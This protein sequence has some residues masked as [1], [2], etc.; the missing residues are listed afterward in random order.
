MSIVYYFLLIGILLLIIE[1]IAILFKITGLDL[2]KSRF[3]TISIITHTGFTTRES[4]LI[5]QHPLHRKIAGYLMII[6]YIGQAGLI[7][8]FLNILK[9]KNYIGIF[10]IVLIIA[11]FILYFSRKR[12]A[13]SKIDL[14]I[15]KTILNKMKKN[16]KYRSVDEV[17]K[18]NDEYGVSE[19]VLNENSTLCN[20]SLDKSNL[21]SRNIQVLNVDRGSHIIHFPQPSLVFKT[22]DKI[23]VYGKIHSITELIMEQQN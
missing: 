22:A 3:Q 16:N 5:S 23:V 11:V 8:I 14:F 10:I 9:E 17:L 19:I 20:I 7:S 1:I 4:E 13:L 15:E 6:S 2:E 21:K 18:L 12:F